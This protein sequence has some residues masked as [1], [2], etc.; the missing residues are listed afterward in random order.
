MDEMRMSRNHG[1]ARGF[2]LV[3]LMIG[4]ALLAILLGLAAPSFSTMIQN[5]RVRGVAESVSSG[6]SL[7]RAEAIKRNAR[8]EFAMTAAATPALASAAAA[9]GGS[10]IVRVLDAAGTPVEIIDSRPVAEGSAGTTVSS[11]AGQTSTGAAFAGTVTFNAFGQANLL[12]AAT[13][14]FEG[15]AGPA[16]CQPAG[17]LRC[18]QVT[19]STA[20]AVKLCD[21]LAAAPDSRAC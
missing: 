13:L 20:G 15:A 19:I 18:L 9:N 7:A 11:P 10:W 5:S 17:P 2:T 16:S 4:L 6:L 14:R 8:V 21:P 12:Q 1:T 3:E